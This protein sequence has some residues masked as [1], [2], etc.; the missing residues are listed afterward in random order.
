MI[1]QTGESREAI[2]LRD[3]E[4]PRLQT[5]A[6]KLLLA[7]LVAG[8]VGGTTGA[9]R[10]QTAADAAPSLLPPPVLTR[11]QLPAEFGRYVRQ[12]RGPASTLELIVGRPHTLNL[13]QPLRRIQVADDSVAR[14]VLLSPA[15]LSILGSQVGSTVLNLWFPHPDDAGKTQLL[16]FLVRVLPDPEVKQHFERACKELE[17]ELN[18]AFPG[19]GVCLVAL[20]DQIAVTGQ[21]R[22][23][24]EAQQ[25]MSIV[26]A[27]AIPFGRQSVEIAARRRVVNMLRVAG[28]A[29]VAPL[30]TAVRPASFTSEVVPTQ[31]SAVPTEPIQPPEIPLRQ[32]PRLIAVAP[33]PQPLQPTVQTER[34]LYL[35]LP[36][37]TAGP[38][39]ERPA[40]ASLFP[41]VLAAPQRS[42][43]EIARSLLP[44]PTGGDAARPALWPAVLEGRPEQRPSLSLPP[45]S[46]PAAQRGVT[47]LLPAVVPSVP[48]PHGPAPT[49]VRVVTPPA[50]PGGAR[51]ALLP[52]VSRWP[53]AGAQRQ[54]PLPHVT[55]GPSAPMPSVAP[56]IQ[57]TSAALPTVPPPVGR[58][59][60]ARP[61]L[62][63]AVPWRKLLGYDQATP[64][65]QP[66]T[67]AEPPAMSQAPVE[68]AVFEAASLSEP[69]VPAPAS[70]SAPP[71]YE[72]APLS[73][74]TAPVTVPPSEPP[75]LE[76]APVSEPPV[77]EAAP[78]SEPPAA[79]A[80]EVVPAV[81]AQPAGRPS[82]ANA[83]PAVLPRLSWGTFFGKPPATRTPEPSSG[84]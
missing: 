77:L 55:A 38:Q 52:E 40:A 59:T 73:E 42:P 35:L 20:G 81:P 64:R 78:P 14:Y 62:L 16:S 60:A 10:G 63:P 74:P 1:G 13:E 25:I 83:R 70:P 24:T 46:G 48:L 4:Q 23:G 67:I 39:G 80:L 53:L 8:A 43:G 44:Q 79:A 12:A 3:P 71:V 34:P 72:A 33:L 54:E 28:T 32:A 26:Q 29:T 61:S 36:A 45:A 9:A 27:N 21:A 11:P 7:G 57:L 66:D 37:P 68:Q 22:D 49:V 41:Q 58:A 75:A 84:P 82:A 2:P 18:R 47:S 15:E 19:S 17:A 50:Q 5:R 30:D 56:A 76:A 51:S 65:P 69:A 31:A 6:V